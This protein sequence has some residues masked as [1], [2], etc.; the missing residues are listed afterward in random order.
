MRGYGHSW[1]K[2]VL[3]G[4]TCRVLVEN[5]TR[6]LDVQSKTFSNPALT[7]HMVFTYKVIYSFGGEKLNLQ[8]AL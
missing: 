2:L 4:V 8:Y 3:Q 6:T 1:G 7:V 5:V